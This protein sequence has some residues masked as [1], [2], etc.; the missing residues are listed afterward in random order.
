MLRGESIPT[1]MNHFLY[2]AGIG[3]E[4]SSYITI[5]GISRGALLK[6]THLLLMKL[7]NWNMSATG[8]AISHLFLIHYIILLLLLFHQSIY[9]E[10]SRSLEHLGED[11]LFFPYSTEF[12]S[13]AEVFNMSLQRSVEPWYIGW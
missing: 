5:F 2:Y 4:T 1:S 13:L 8:N 7:H 10:G 6:G 12:R 3:E 11:C 9:G